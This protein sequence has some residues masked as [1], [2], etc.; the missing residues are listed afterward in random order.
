MYRKKYRSI[1]KD[2]GFT[3]EVLDNTNEVLDN[4]VRIIFFVL[5]VLSLI[6]C[7]V[8]AC[9]DLHFLRLKIE[10]ETEAHPARNSIQPLPSELPLIRITLD[11]NAAVSTNDEYTLGRVTCT[12]GNATSPSA[13]AGVRVRGSGSRTFPQNSYNLEFREESD[14][15]QD[16][17]KSL[18]GI[19]GGKELEDW[20]LVQTWSDASALRT[21]TA[22]E[23]WK[24]LAND[25][26]GFYLESELVEVILN[27]QYVGVYL[28]AEAIKRKT[29]TFL[30]AD[31]KTDEHIQSTKASKGLRGILFERGGNEPCFDGYEF[32]YPKC[33][34]L[35]DTGFDAQV[36][37]HLKEIT[38]ALAA[39]DRPYIE[40]LVDVNS[41]VDHVL[42]GELFKDVDAYGRSEYFYIK[43]MNGGGSQDRLLRAGP[44]WDFDM[45]SGTVHLPYDLHWEGFAFDRT[46]YAPINPWI[47]SLVKKKWFTDMLRTRFVETKQ[48]MMN[49]SESLRYLDAPSDSNHAKTYELLGRCNLFKQSRHWKRG[50]WEKICWHPTYL[51]EVGRLRGWLRSR[52][53]WLDATP[54][55]AGKDSPTYE[56]KKPAGDL[57]RKIIPVTLLSFIFV[58]IITFSFI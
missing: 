16:T 57:A 35:K 46:S 56:F 1:Q 34:V 39:N 24:L 36:R 58:V 38:T 23:V 10:D 33:S 44:E 3:N 45:S 28:A 29:Y 50:G 11:G 43:N 9:I 48:K 40:S 53:S 32:D 15:S 4:S 55:V 41:F 19:S 31:N 49:F 13:R 17:E 42:V 8:L 5:C 12:V 18:C 30:D 20:R 37:D 25:T 27:E 52:I 2:D 7:Y 51:E 26:Q 54:F 6:A 21:K 14:P 22:F 47:L